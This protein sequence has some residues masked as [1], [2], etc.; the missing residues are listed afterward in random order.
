MRGKTLFG[1]SEG[2]LSSLVF[3]F[4]SWLAA[5]SE[6]LAEKATARMC[7]AFCKVACGYLGQ[8]K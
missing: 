2:E 4:R 1:I 7:W 8:E 5:A 3:R 6:A